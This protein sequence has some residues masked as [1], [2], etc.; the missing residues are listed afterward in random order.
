MSTNDTTPRSAVQWAIPAVAVA[1]GIAYLI[2]GIVGDEVGF[3]IFGLILMLAIAAAL[4]LIRRRSET[5]QG[6][7]DRRD[8]RIVQIDVK[9]TAFAG[10]VVIVAVL[11]GFV[12]EI[13]RGNDGMPYA[14]LGAIGGVAY[15][16]AVAWY[17]L[18]G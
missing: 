6:L 10:G 16:A 2:A 7:M 5:V 8:E 18:R 4:L 17:R 12:V 15:V 14:G 13:A 3:G 9:A 11:T 1:I